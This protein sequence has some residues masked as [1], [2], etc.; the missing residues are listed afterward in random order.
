VAVVVL[1]FALFLPVQSECPDAAACRQA[2]IDA[3]ARG[4]FEASHDLAWRAV[5]KGRAND[6]ALL[7]Q[8]A[9][10][11]SMSGRPG[12]AL[13]MLRRL[14]QMGV[15]VDDAVTSDDFRR[16]RALDGWPEVEAMLKAGG[17]PPDAPAETPAAPPPTKAK[18]AKAERGD[19]AARAKPRAALPGAAAATDDESLPGDVG[20]IEPA[21]LAYDAVSRRF[22]VGD[23]HENKLVIFDDVF[24]RVTNM[25]GAESAG[26]FGLTAL[27]IDRRRGDLWVA[28]SSAGRGASL[29]KLQLVSGR[30]LFELPLPADLGPATVVDLAVLENGE[31]LLLDAQGRRLLGLSP[32]Q[33][34]F[35]TVVTTNVTDATSLA[36]V[37]SGLAYVAHPRGLLRVD[38]AAR[39]T[40]D[41]GN[42]PLDLRRIR[43]HAG[44]LIAIRSDEAGQ[45]LIRLRLGGSGRTV[46][47]M[48]VL[49]DHAEMP[50]A[51]AM[52]NVDGV[53]SY[54]TASKG[55]LVMR[56]KRLGR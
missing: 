12:D 39:T 9:R 20:S 50:D 8:L 46:T 35:R 10:A 41:V 53:A 33:R 4:D 49:D 34:T 51:S 3:G 17:R 26:F 47:Q 6:P 23:R 30:V 15:A 37:G 19:E 28:N 40:T 43:P 45:R 1:W 29:H 56:R 24:K 54:I 27:E 16:V 36:S 14:V 25:A 7:T 52:T 13:V 22:I 21:G 48:Q 31:V 42:A 38:L 11:Q 5:Q 55:A 44:Q 18:A 2:S 32:G